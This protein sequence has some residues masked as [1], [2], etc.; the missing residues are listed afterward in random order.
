MKQE[1]LIEKHIFSTQ[2]DQ[3]RF[4]LKY[5]RKITNTNASVSCSMQRKSRFGVTLETMVTNNYCQFSLCSV[6]LVED[7]R[8]LSPSRDR[9]RLQHL[10][11]YQLGF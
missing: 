9:Q 11:L 5:V 3:I 7:C 8:P 6:Y 4:P 2:N 10:D 1:L